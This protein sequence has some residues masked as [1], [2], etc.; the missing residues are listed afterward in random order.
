[1]TERRK[2][3]FLESQN[4]TCLSYSSPSHVLN[5]NWL[6]KENHTD[7]DEWTAKDKLN[8]EGLNEKVI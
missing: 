6:Q 3:I 8:T 5:A 1:M 4:N 2:I 7:R